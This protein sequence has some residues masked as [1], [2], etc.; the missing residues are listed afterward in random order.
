MANYNRHSAHSAY[1]TDRCV[2]IAQP[3]M[4]NLVKL[5]QQTG[6]QL[7]SSIGS[8]KFGMFFLFTAQSLCGT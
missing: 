6:D 7:L 5:R 1:Y 3:N 8:D 4:C 2:D